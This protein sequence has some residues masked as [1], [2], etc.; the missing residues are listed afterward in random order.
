MI[1][2][3]IISAALLTPVLLT[4]VVTHPSVGYVAVSDWGGS[5]N[6]RGFENLLWATTTAVITAPA[7]TALLVTI[8]REHRVGCLAI[9]GGHRSTI[10]R[11]GT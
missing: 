9:S 11:H 4:A 6:A 5:S 3:A 1:T 8:G 10:T 2:S 7:V